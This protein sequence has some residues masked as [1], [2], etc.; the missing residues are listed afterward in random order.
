MGIYDMAD[1]LTYDDIR[2]ML[3]PRM[4]QG[5]PDTVIDEINILLADPDMGE[6]YREN[7]ISYQSVLTEGR[8]KLPN[9]ISAIKYVSHKLSGITNKDAYART[10]P[11]KIIEWDVRGVPN[12]DRDSY[13]SAYHNSK[14]VTLILEQ[15]MIPTWVANQDLYQEALLKQR[16]LMTSAKSEFVQFQAAK[17]I[18]DSLK[19]PD[20]VKLKLDMGVAENTVLT[21]V[22]DSIEKLVA[23]QRQSL[24][25][26]NMS[27]KEI[28]EM[29]I[30]EAEYVE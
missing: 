24:E 19:R 1:Q 5:V 18:M 7:L 9:Y 10:F 11:D 30:I 25:S 4:A 16:E 12:K 28:A 26:G 27:A 13:I 29:D 2:T 6:R 8:F 23:A 22:K 17:A 21:S 3:P 20:A 15:S 14:L